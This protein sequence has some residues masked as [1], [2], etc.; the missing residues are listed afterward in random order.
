MPTTRVTMALRL[1]KPQNPSERPG[2]RTAELGARAQTLLAAGDL[3]G[4]RAL[5]AVAADEP[6][7]HRRYAAR[8]ALLETGL[9]IP[10]G[11]VNQFAGV[12]VAVATE[13]LT[14]L[15]EQ[16]AEPVV[17]NITGVA[18]YELGALAGAK[19]LFE[20]AQSLNPDL[21]HVRRN[22]SEVARRRRQGINPRVP[23]AVMGVLRSLEADA[24]RMA[25]RAKPVDGLTLSLC[26]IV[27]DEEAML[28]RC[29][30]AAAPHVDEIIVVDTGS[31]DATIEIAK[32]FGAKVIEV[33]WT[34]D[35]AAARNVSFDAATSDWL[36][37][38][39]ADEVLAEGEGERLRALTGKVWRE[40]FFLVET[41]HTGQLEDGTSVH[42]N[43]LRVF[44]NRPEYRFKGRIHEQIAHTLPGDLPERFEATDVRIDHFGY[45]GVVREE[46]D[47][48]RRNLELL[49]RQLEEG[50]PT[51][52]LHFNLGS[53][54][55]ALGENE[56][57]LEYFRQAW[58][59]ATAQGDIRQFGF[60]PSLASRFASALRIDGAIAELDA[61]VKAALAIFPGFTDLVFDLALAHARAED[62]ARAIELFETCLAMGD[63]PSAY[64]ATVG[65]GSYSALTALA[66]SHRALG[67]LEQAESAGRRALEAN[68]RFLAAVDP[69]ASIMLER[70][71][72]ADDV[73]AEIHGLV[74]EDTP[75]LRFVLAIS[76]YEAGA[77][78]AAE[79]ELRAALERQPHNAPVRAALAEALLSQRRYADAAEVAAAMAPE[80]PAAIPAARAELFGRLAGGEPAAA[81]D[82]AFARA[83]AA[84]V[85]GDD[86][87]LFEAWR[88]LSDGTAASADPL[89][90]GAVE[91]L[92]SIYEALLRVQD[93]D[94]FVALLPLTERIPMDTRLRRD[95]M[96]HM[97]LRRGFVDSAADEW[98]AACEEH[99]PHAGALAG[100]AAVAVI[101]EVH[102]DAALFARTALELEPGHPVAARV[103]ARL[104]L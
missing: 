13:G 72:P 47:K 6:D 1:S 15:A 12:F 22:L 50:D 78:E 23:A 27:R 68:P 100:L 28:P 94:P 48:S 64:S 56:P 20:A 89:P 83:R 38:L 99:G 37:F 43:A 9:S 75:A 76:L 16:P 69:L 46:K 32:S 35:F 26:M 44:R 97:Y 49:Q 24:K 104:G 54:H 40:A 45:L 53:E 74:A 73:A 39:D 71:I 96:A 102:E 60:A 93:V 30:E 42:H 63:A 61:H 58:A 8:R 91:L 77:A 65:C 2:L 88:G 86:L 34:G 90:P 81:L 92:F 62:H 101:N 41:N 51:P 67:Q 7:V 52:F 80:A 31:T 85:P 55:G 3:P 14:I 98:A 66:D 82:D 103:L 79:R 18:L 10:R 70:D 11:N 36:V 87:A 59:G 5:F 21:P 17:L 57:A 19:A 33:E 84:G 29:L 25:K 4:Y 95:R